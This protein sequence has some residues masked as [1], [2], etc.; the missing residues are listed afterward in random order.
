M[1]EWAGLLAILLTNLNWKG[2][3]GNHPESIH[4]ISHWL[5]QHWPAGGTSGESFMRTAWG[6]AGE[7]IRQSSNNINC[8]KWGDWAKA[9]ISESFLFLYD[10]CLLLK[11]RWDGW[12]ISEKSRVVGRALA[13]GDGDGSLFS[14]PYSLG[15]RSIAVACLPCPA[16]QTQHKDQA[17]ITWDCSNPLKA[18]TSL[19][20]NTGIFIW[21]L[22]GSKIMEKS[23]ENITCT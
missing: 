7:W 11:A 9:W 6:G 13:S 4:W 19:D 17:K 15:A 22:R 20:N 5:C 2:H 3:L 12:D 21:E 1:A 18:V 16:S 23:W 14:A 8:P 10:S